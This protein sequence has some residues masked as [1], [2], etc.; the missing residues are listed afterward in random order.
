MQ[1]AAY[2]EMDKM[3]LTELHR[4]ISRTTGIEDFD[5][6]EVS[7]YYSLTGSVN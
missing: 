3:K 6:K 7:P 1:L 4:E 2:L 5:R